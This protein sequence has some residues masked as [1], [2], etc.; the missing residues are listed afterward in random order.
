MERDKIKNF[1]LD[2]LFFA[3]GFT[4]EQSEQIERVQKV[5]VRD[6]LLDFKTSYRVALNT[7]GL[8]TLQIRRVKLCKKFA[9]KTIR[10]RHRY[11]FT[12]LFTVY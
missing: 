3:S 1:G 10:S 6:I 11:M 2:L 8:E 4:R 12:E 7:L 9:R 5:S